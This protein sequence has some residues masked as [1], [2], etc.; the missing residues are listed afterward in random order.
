MIIATV[1][2]ATYGLSLVVRVDRISAQRLLGL[3]LGLVAV[4][5]LVYSQFGEVRGGS[6]IWIVLALLIPAAY[7]FENLFVALRRPPLMDEV[8]LVAGMMLAGTI[9]L[10]PIVL[11]TDSGVSMRLPWGQVQ[12]A[13]LAMAVVN[14]FSYT[15]FLYLI[16][17]AGP[18]FAALAGYFTM[19]SGVLWGMAL[20]GETHGPVVWAAFAVMV[21]G[22]LLV[23]E[24]PVVRSKG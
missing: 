24:R 16:Q 7:S 18:V 17:V 10:V 4:A 19:L 23:R 5:L 21:V 14:V 2:L 13:C 3:I 1:P 9:V 8:T 6:I 12:W 20:F 11:A 15:V 22:M